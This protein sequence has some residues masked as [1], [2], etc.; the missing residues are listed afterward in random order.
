MRRCFQFSVIGTENCKRWYRYIMD[1]I[2]NGVQPGSVK[3]V[4]PAALFY[5]FTVSAMEASNKTSDADVNVAVG[6][7]NTKLL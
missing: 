7:K 3:M 2:V 5:F 4:P 6:A 1:I